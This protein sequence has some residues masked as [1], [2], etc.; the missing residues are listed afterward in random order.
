MCTTR[1]QAR[2]RCIVDT[3]LFANNLKED[4]LV[5]LEDKVNNS[6]LNLTI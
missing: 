3:A 1:E 2:T 5:L 4:V 6:L